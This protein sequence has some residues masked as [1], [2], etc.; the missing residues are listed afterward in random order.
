MRVWDGDENIA[1]QRR[2]S[3]TRE[4]AGKTRGLVDE[5]DATKICDRSRYDALGFAFLICVRAIFFVFL[6]FLRFR[7]PA[8]LAPI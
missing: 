3:E 1:R 8:W 2:R 5:R 6:S 4:P 7:S